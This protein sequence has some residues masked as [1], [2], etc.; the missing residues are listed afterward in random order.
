VTFSEWLETKTNASRLEACELVLARFRATADADPEFMSGVGTAL[1]ALLS[2]CPGEDSQDLLAEMRSRMG[3]L[4]RQRLDDLS[5]RLL[6]ATGA[7]SEIECEAGK[8]V[9]FWFRTIGL[10]SG[11]FTP[12]RRALHAARAYEHTFAALGRLIDRVDAPQRSDRE[13]VA[14]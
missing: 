14:A 10:C 12:S 13:R 8:L 2:T 4:G 3:A 11:P 1:W 9:S 7:K 6:N 5:C